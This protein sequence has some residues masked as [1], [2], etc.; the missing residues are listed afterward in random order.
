MLFGEGRGGREEEE[1]P[2]KNVQIAGA[3]EGGK[4]K[5]KVPHAKI[6]II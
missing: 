3:R 4:T 2:G 1:D 6:I 5:I